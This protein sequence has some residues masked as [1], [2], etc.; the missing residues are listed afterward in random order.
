[1]SE[2]IFIALIVAVLGVGVAYIFYVM[3]G[4]NDGDSRH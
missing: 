2:N 4:G 3:E 1:M